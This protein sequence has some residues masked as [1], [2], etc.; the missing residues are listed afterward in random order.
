MNIVFV[1]VMMMTVG[2]I[3]TDLTFNTLQQ[4]EVVAATAKENGIE[5]AFCIEKQVKKKKLN[6][7]IENRT[8]YYSGHAGNNHN[9]DGYPYPV[10]ISCVEE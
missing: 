7:K 10:G 2:G 8:D 4:C 6:C 5:R 3:N 1:L 9:M